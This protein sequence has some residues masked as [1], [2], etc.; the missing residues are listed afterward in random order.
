MSSRTEQADLS[1]SLPMEVSWH[2]DFGC[3]LYSICENFIS[4]S[5]E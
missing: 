5:N 1:P 4:L 3:Y 2:A